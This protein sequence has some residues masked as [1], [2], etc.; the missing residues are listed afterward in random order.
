M[1]R[2]IYIILSLLLVLT[3]C[4][5][6]VRDEIA[7]LHQDIDAVKTRLDALANE[8]NTN[9]SSLRTIVEA[10]QNNDFVQK[11]VP[12]MENGKEA[13][14]EITF[15]KMGKITIYHGH[16]GEDGTDGTDGVVPQ[17]GIRQDKDGNWYWTMDGT[18]LLDDEGQRVRAVGKDGSNGADGEDGQDGQNG[19]DGIAGVDGVT[20]QFKIENGYWFVSY[21]KGLTWSRLGKATGADGAPGKDADLAESV[22]KDVQILENDVVFTLKDGT[23]ITINRNRA[24][25]ISFEETSGILCAPGKTVRIPYTITGGDSRTFVECMADEGW[26]ARVESTDTR[27]GYVCVT[28]PDPMGNGKV[29]VFVNA[30][31]G[32]TYVTKLS[33]VEGHPMVENS[34]FYVNYKGGTVEVAVTAR[35]DYDIKIAGTPAWISLEP[36]MKAAERVDLLKF[37]VQK[38]PFSVEREAEVQLYSDSG[39]LIESF[40]IKQYKNNSSE[41]AII[42]ADPDVEKLCVDNFDTDGDGY[43]SFAEAAAVETLGSIFRYNG[44][45]DTFEE[46]QYFT[47]LA[48]LDKGFDNCY[49][50]KKIILPENLTVIK[51]SAFVNCEKLYSVVLPNNLEK[52]ESHAFYNCSGLSNMSIPASLKEIGDDAFGDCQTLTEMILP[53]G[54]VSIGDDAFN[55][56]TALS[57]VVLPSTLYEVGTGIFED[58]L[59]LKVISIPDNITQ[60]PSSMFAGC[61]NL[62]EINFSPNVTEIGSHA[63]YDCTSLSSLQLPQRLLKIGHAAFYGCISLTSVEFPELINWLGHEVF[64]KCINLKSIVLPKLIT[65]LGPNLFNGCSNMESVTIQGNVTSISNGVFTGCSS[66]NEV[67][68]LPQT[69]PSLYYSD[70]FSSAKATMKIKVPAGSVEAYKASYNWSGYADKIVAITSEE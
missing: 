33:I 37:I 29:L 25:K 66:L 13:G 68:C 54:L 28:A 5:K 36:V 47:K 57:K 22:F 50:L 60:I 21:D 30:G 70:T 58:C 51:S 43:V 61:K 32:R 48:T 63:F 34:I 45:I 18:W 11:V 46:L 67:I 10:L 55:N 24:L 62:S 16:D 64:C 69:P 41:G 8:M 53:E 2:Y 49:Y 23:V 40:K 42:F 17:F 3:G 14:Y 4:D 44:S 15:S 20:P 9:I 26:K 27:S 59:A 31:D 56:C 19:T 65:E 35:E 52:I 7:Q 12:F 6:M 38:N 39:D 1:K